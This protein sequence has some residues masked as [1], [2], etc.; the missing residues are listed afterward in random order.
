MGGGRAELPVIDLEA[1]R[2]AGPH[3]DDSFTLNEMVE[4]VDIIPIETHPNAL[5]GSAT[6]IHLGRDHYYLS[7][8][9]KITC[10]GRDGKIV[11][12]IARQGRGPGEYIYLGPADVNEEASTIRVFDRA[13]DKYITYDMQGRLID[14]V[15]LRE[16]GLGLPMFVADNHIVV[17]G[18]ADGAFRLLVTDR[19]MNVV[20]GLF[21]MDTT[22]TELDRSWL[23][24]LVGD[25]SDGEEALV[26]LSTEDTLYRVTKRG[27]TPEMILHRG[28]YRRAAEPII[29]EISPDMPET[30]TQTRVNVFGDYLF[31]R[32]MVQG[33]I[34]QA[35]DRERGVVIAHTDIRDGIEQYGFRFVFPSGGETRVSGWLTEGDTM[36]F[37]V[38][39]I[40]IAGAVDGVKEDDNPVIVIAKL[41]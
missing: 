30:F 11:N 19:D 17:R 34:L 35:L 31:I 33:L 25:G 12:T 20:R 10:V 1:A 23:K 15:S 9:N 16:K 40:H 5:I 22:L 14:E 3:L 37:T 39:A 13:G 36:A 27:L 8:D 26:N 18:R 29:Q 28:Q 41:K 7:H 2:N 32:Q 4:V 21:P 6:L 38:D 24:E